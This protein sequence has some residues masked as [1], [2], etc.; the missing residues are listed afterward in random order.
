MRDFLCLKTV[1]LWIII[2]VST[3]VCELI[4]RSQDLAVK[5]GLDSSQ[6]VCP[7][8][9]CDGCKC[10]YLETPDP[11]LED[12]IDRHQDKE[13]QKLIGTRNVIKFYGKLKESI[14]IR[15]NSQSSRT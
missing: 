5:R 14:Q 15:I 13:V 9:S 3:T 7:C 6:V 10:P 12:P 1:L 4:K 11:I 2:L 8:D